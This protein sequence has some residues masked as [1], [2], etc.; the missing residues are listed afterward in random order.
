MSADHAGRRASLA[1][2]TLVELRK[3]VDTPAGIAICV[4]S[5]LLAGVFGGGAVLYQQPASIGDIAL[6]AGVPG[7]TL[8]P[9]LAIL[10]VTAERTHRTA[11]ATY[12]LTPRRHRVLLGKAGAAVALSVAV[13]PLALLAAVVIGP[14]GSLVTGD[15]TAWTV[16]GGGVGRFTLIN[17]ILALTGYVLALAT[18]N[19]PTSIVIVLTWPMLESM[20]RAASPTIG[21]IVRWLDVAAVTEDVSRAATALAFW[22]VVPALVGFRRALRAEVR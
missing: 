3:V 6:M 4:V 18:G 16:D 10:L 19:A 2:L 13:T 8:V 12:A 9:V 5:A 11:L 22:V 21:A 14:V 7:G 1:M 15:P 17:V 20:L